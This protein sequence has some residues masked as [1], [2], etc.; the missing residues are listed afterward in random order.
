MTPEKRIEM[1]IRA[2]VAA[3]PH[4]WSVKLHADGHQGRGTLDLLGGYQGHPFL[5]EVK[6]VGGEAS[7]IQ[8]ALVRQAQR[9]GFV[10]GIIDSVAAFVALFEQV[11]DGKPSGLQELHPDDAV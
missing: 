5:V 7:K 11:D 9:G 10:S 1:K 2:H 4:G 3:T 8:D 6:R